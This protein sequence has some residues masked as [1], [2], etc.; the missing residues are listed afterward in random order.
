MRRWQ[1][2]LLGLLVAVACSVLGGLPISEVSADPTSGEC[3]GRASTQSSSCLHTLRKSTISIQLRTLDPAPQSDISS[4]YALE[5]KEF[6]GTNGR[7]PELVIGCRAGATILWID[8][9]VAAAI[10]TP[11]VSVWT[12]SDDPIVS[13]WR[14]S[15]DRHRIYAPSP[16]VL[17]ARIAAAKRFEVELTRRSGTRLKA[18]FD[19]A[20]IPAELSP[21]AGICRDPSG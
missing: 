19:A 10:A 2:V 6:S 14:L 12:E 9:K 15:G 18:V 17:L 7:R 20:S 5:A 13:I 3:R 21:V 4:L 11:I 1:Q 8:W 16:S